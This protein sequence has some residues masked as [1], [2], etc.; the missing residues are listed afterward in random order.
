MRRDPLWLRR[1]AGTRFD[2]P[3]RGTARARRPFAFAEGVWL[4][5]QFASGE[6]AEGTGARVSPAA[7]AAGRRHRYSGRARAD[8]WP[9]F[10]P[11]EEDRGSHLR[12]E[13][14]PP[15]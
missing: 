13:A 9:L 5:R 1:I 15:G 4:V 7:R 2:D 11:A 3:Q 12:R 10:R 14:G 6:I 8:R